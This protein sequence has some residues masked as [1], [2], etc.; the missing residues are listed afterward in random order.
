M[1]MELRH[2][3]S[4]IRVATEG[5]FSRAAASLH[6]AQPALSQQIRQLEEEFGTQLF[7]RHARGVR[8]SPAGEDLL[9][10]AIKVLDQVASIRSRFLQAHSTQRT[11]VRL[12]LPTSVVRVLGVVVANAI[13]HRLPNIKLQIVEGMTGFLY[14]W[15]SAEQLDVAILY[16][17]LFY[18]DVPANLIFKPVVREEFFLITPVGLVDDQA[19]LCLADLE[20]FP[21]VLPRKMHAIRALIDDF[22]RLNQ[23]DL[24]ILSEVDSFPMLL[25]RVRTGSCTLLPATAV[26][27]ELADGLVEAFPIIPPPLRTLNVAY[28]KASQNREIIDSVIGALLEVAD[29]LTSEGIWKAIPIR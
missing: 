18:K 2:L 24:Q 17:S 19:S 29:S 8:L 27:H 9:P 10:E 6:V 13:E 22:T 5:S 3:K 16:D 25:E 20:K 21:L 15:L 7:V 23:L 1:R 4:F 28:S 12:G 26:V 14:D 11:E